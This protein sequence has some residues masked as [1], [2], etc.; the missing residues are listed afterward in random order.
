MSENQTKR[1]KTMMRKFLS[2]V[3]LSVLFILPMCKCD[4]DCDYDEDINPPETNAVV[5]V[6]DDGYW[7]VNGT[8]TEVIADEGNSPKLEISDDGYWVIDGVK[9]N[10]PAT[11]QE[12]SDCIPF[13]SV[14][15]VRWDS[16]TLT[17]IN[18]PDN[19]GGYDFTDAQYQWYHNGRR[20]RNSTGQSLLRNPNGGMLAAGH[21]HVEIRYRGG[22][23][24]TCMEYCAFDNSL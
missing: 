9:T 21:Y 11:I 12:P 6:S 2:I 3:L 8:K 24:I 22:F 5:T 20:L 17:V 23:L 1:S 13:Y 19:N 15:I 18:N 4:C 16:N 14:V 10:T 7:V